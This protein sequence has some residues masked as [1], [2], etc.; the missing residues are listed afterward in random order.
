MVAIEELTDFKEYIIIIY[1]ASDTT[2][3]AAV[4]EDESALPDQS[5][6]SIQQRRGINILHSHGTPSCFL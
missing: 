4:I 3:R 2:V 6:L 5:D 1:L